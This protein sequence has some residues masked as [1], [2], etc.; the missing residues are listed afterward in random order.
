MYPPAT[1]SGP[2]SA[3][4][5]FDIRWQPLRG[6]RYS[7]W[8]LCPRSLPSAATLPIAPE[9]FD[10]LLASH[11][12]LLPVAAGQQLIL[13]TAPPL[14]VVAADT[15]TLPEA[16]VLVVVLEKFCIVDRRSTVEEYTG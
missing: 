16:V 14:V 3:Q 1:S 10:H 11:L 7:S 5:G 13:A 12:E 2:S 6:V 8:Q 15:D 9:G 4:T